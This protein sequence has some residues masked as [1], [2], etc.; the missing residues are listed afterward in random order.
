MEIEIEIS[1]WDTKYN[2]KKNQKTYTW[3]KVN[4]DIIDGSDY[5]GLNHTERYIFISLVLL[6]TKKG[7]HKFWLKLNWF[8]SVTGLPQDIIVGSIEKLKGDN[9]KLLG[10][11]NKQQ[12]ALPENPPE[13]AGEDRDTPEKTSPTDGRTDGSNGLTDVDLNKSEFTF[14]VPDSM[15]PKPRERPSF[16]LSSEKVGA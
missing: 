1:D 3:G 5:Y 2:P 11:H 15:Q 8:T 12:M 6:A 14:V 9:Y 13:F 16:K 7:S 4:V 10:N